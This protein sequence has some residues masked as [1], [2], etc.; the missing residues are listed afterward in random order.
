MLNNTCGVSVKIIPNSVK[1][2]LK[3]LTQRKL[4]TGVKIGSATGVNFKF[5]TSFFQFVMCRNLNLENKMHSL[6]S[7]IYGLNKN[8]SILF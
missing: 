2:A 7:K 1:I 4:N 5:N 8:K 6:E 3:K